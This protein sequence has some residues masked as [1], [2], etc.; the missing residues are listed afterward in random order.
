[1]GTSIVVTSG[2]GGVGKT[3][4]TASLSLALVQAG[5]TVCAV[6]LDVGL[7]NLD[8]C[9]GLSDRIIYDMTDVLS[10]KVALS[11]ALIEH[12]NYHDQLFLLAASQ[13]D[14][15]EVLDV[16]KIQ[17]IIGELKQQYDFVLLDCPAGIETGFKAAVYVADSAIIVTTPELAAVSDADRVVGLLEKMKLSYGIHLV[18]NRV[19]LQMIENGKAMDIQSIVNRLSV[20][21]IGVIID[22]DDVIATSNHGQSVLQEDIENPAAVGYRNLAHR[23]LGEKIPLNEIDEHRLSSKKQNFWQRMFH[24]VN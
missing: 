15:Q 22:D 2:K 13:N 12:P 16:R 6:D 21:L 20:P 23:I 8:S 9:L 1:M 4:T 17:A 3:T 7:R 18:I 24:H 19:R 11:Q 14:S 10:G 5:K